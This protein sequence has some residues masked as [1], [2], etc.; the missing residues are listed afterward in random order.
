L[1]WQEL[2]GPS[3]ALAGE[4]LSVDWWTTLAIASAAVDLR[5]YPAS[6]AAYLQDGLPPHPPW[7]I[8]SGVR[9]P[10]DRLKATLAHLAAQGP[11][12][13]YQGDLARSLAADVQAGGGAVDRGPCSL[14]RP[15]ARAAGHSLSRRHGVRDA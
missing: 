2:L 9:L 3:V 4:G 13:F 7:G 10:Q 6:A 8:K 15:W 11:R 14:P 1:P 12:D 5:R